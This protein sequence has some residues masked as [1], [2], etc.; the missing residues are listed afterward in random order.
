M[1]LTVLTHASCCMCNLHLLYVF[2]LNVLSNCIMRIFGDPG[3]VGD[4]V[5][6]PGSPKNS[7]ERI[8]RALRHN[9]RTY[10][11]ES[12]NNG[13]R[14]YYKQRKRS[15][16]SGPATVLGQDDQFVLAFFLLNAANM[17]EENEK[18]ARTTLCYQL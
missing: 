16:W 18:L 9:V 8:R 15:G 14:V 12:F 2:S 3:A 17:T 13:D 1:T 4:E 5:K 7:S 10:A 11:D 6:A